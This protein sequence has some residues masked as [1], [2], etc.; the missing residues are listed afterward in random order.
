MK[1]V[2]KFP[3]LK[4]SQNL[5]EKVDKILNHTLVRREILAA[6]EPNSA[7]RQPGT[8]IKYPYRVNLYIT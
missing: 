4:G 2:C 6:F 8:I 3:E 1:G 5:C 7:E